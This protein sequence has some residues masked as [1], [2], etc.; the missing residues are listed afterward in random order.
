MVRSELHAI[1]V[2]AVL[3]LTASNWPREAR[4]QSA[5]ELE[6]LRTQ[7]NQLYS[8]GKYVQAAP[9]AERYVA[10]ARQRMAKTT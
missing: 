8:Q 6:S 2:F 5:D 1:V 4:A 7:V 9:M 3:L 10:W